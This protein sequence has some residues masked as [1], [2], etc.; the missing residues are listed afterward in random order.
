MDKAERLLSEAN[1]RLKR[2]N[3]GISIFKRGQKLSL[4][5]MLPPKPGKSKRSQQTIKL[6]IF[7]NP[8]GIK[9]AEKQAQQLASELAL[10]QFNWNKWTSSNHQSIESV[11]YWIEKF[12]ADYYKRKERNDKT[13]TT[14][15]SEY[16]AMFNRLSKNEK[17]SDRLLLDLV[18]STEPDSRQRKR[19]CMVAGALAKFAKIDLDLSAYRGNY[20]SRNSPKDLPSDRQIML[21]Y[22][23]IPNPQWQFVFG[24]MAAY[25][26]SNHELFYVDLSSLQKSPGHLVSSYRKAHYGIRNI[27]CLYPEWYEQWELYKP[28]SL[29]DV[30]GKNNQT[31]GSRVTKAFKRYGICKPTWI[32]HCWAIRAMGFMPNPMAARMMAHSEQE[33]FKTY[34]RWINQDQEQKMYEILMSRS[35]RPKPPII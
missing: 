7:C 15:N 30:S 20:N 5:G 24:L 4:R 25:G 13:E 32:R 27:W 23:Q 34:Q 10:N 35:D 14:W 6:D 28:K 17:L 26:I 33:H 1:Q 9:S 31:L 11:S 8:A 2:S 21:W 16:R 3:T 12:E 29:P 18:F 19:A 22:E